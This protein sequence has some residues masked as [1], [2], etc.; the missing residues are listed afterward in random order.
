MKL[1]AVAGE[2]VRLENLSK[3][4]LVK[5]HNIFNCLKY[6]IE[7]ETGVSVSKIVLNK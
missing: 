6:E 3:G 1:S 4:A 5:V 7:E 2:K